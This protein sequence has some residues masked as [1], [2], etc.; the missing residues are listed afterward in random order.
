[1]AENIG[2]SDSTSLKTD[3]ILP[4]T[5][6]HGLWNTSKNQTIV[7]EHSS[8]LLHPKRHVETTKQR[9]KNNKYS[10]MAPEITSSFLGPGSLKMD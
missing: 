7:C 6:L 4:W 8:L 5:S 3:T 1:M 10:K 9:G 2:P